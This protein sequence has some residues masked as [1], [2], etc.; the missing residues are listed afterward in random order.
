MSADVYT[1]MFKML[2]YLPLTQG[3]LAM[4]E[5]DAVTHFLF[6]F[7][8]KYCCITWNYLYKYLRNILS[9]M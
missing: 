4:F 6:L 8:L 3:E 7:L 9:Y 2:H 5:M 1:G